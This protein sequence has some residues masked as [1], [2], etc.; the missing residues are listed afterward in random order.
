MR[1]LVSRRTFKRKWG[2]RRR[3]SE[4]GTLLFMLFLA[5]F[6]NHALRFFFVMIN[7]SLKVFLLP[8]GGLINEMVALDVFFLFFLS[9]LLL[10]YLEQTSHNCMSQ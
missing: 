1:V 2:F 7:G 4:L 9:K 5:Y 8:L 3:V 6:C 10:E